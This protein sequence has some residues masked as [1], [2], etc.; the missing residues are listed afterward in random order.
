MGLQQ[1]DNSRFQEALRQQREQAEAEQSEDEQGAQDNTE[2][3]PSKEEPKE[4]PKEGS[5]DD[6]ALIIMSV[7]ASSLCLFVILAVMFFRKKR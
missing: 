6:T 1:V 3:A 2:D 7:S 5:S 4:E